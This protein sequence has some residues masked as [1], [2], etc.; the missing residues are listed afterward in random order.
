VADRSDA[1]NHKPGLIA[2]KRCI[3]TAKSFARGDSGFA[4]VDAV[5]PGWNETIT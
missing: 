5:S 3:G 1:T 4:W 2:H